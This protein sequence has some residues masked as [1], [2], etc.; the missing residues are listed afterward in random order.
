VVEEENFVQWH[1]PRPEY[2]RELEP[3]LSRKAWETP[4]QMPMP[5]YPLRQTCDWL[6]DL[7]NYLLKPDPPMLQQKLNGATVACWL[8]RDRR[9]AEQWCDRQ[10]RKMGFWMRF[11][12][13]PIRFRVGRPGGSIPKKLPQAVQLQ[14]KRAKKL[15]AIGAGA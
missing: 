3:G 13:A 1:T 9:L 10:L 8:T 14:F 2:M 11:D 5:N 12:A 7:L 6:A 4:P 15:K